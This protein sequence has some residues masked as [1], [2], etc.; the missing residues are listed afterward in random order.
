MKHGR[1]GGVVLWLILLA[2]AG[3]G[4]PG[5]AV[6]PTPTA[7]ATA[8]PAPARALIAPAPPAGWAL[9]PVTVRAYLASVGPFTN[10]SAIALAPEQSLAYLDDTI[11]TLEGV[12]PPA[13][14]APAHETLLKGYRAIAEGRR[15]ITQDV[16][17]NELRAEGY[18]LLDW[19]QAL[20][21]EYVQI[22]AAHVAALQATRQP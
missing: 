18:S 16:R 4:G 20:L 22:V 7:A 15:L 2:L 6:D 13:D 3:C 14:L 11:A 21:R 10:G 8:T 1:R 5:P 12:V 9:V 17:N 19:G